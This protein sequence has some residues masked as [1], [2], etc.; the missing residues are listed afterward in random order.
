LPLRR[1]RR[2]SDRPS[3]RRLVRGTLLVGSIG[4]ALHLVFPQ[5]PGIERS[6]RLVAGTSHLL[7]GVALL[8]EVTSELSYAELLGRSVGMMSHRRPGR[9][10]MLRLT[11]T[12]YGAAHVLP[13]GGAAATAVAYG[14]LRRQGY[15]PERVGLALAAVSVLIYGA[16]GMFFS[17]S[18]LFMLLNRDLGPAD[19][20]ASIFVLGLTVSV[21]LGAYV[22]YRRPTLA[23]NVA[24]R[25]TRFAGRLLA[26]E[27]L[28][29]RAGVWSVRLVS[30]LG[31]VLQAGRQHLA[32]RSAE[33]PRLAAL[34]LGY[35]IFDALCL[36]LMF[37]ALGVAADP[38]VLLVAY[39]VAT[40]I[41]AVPLT[42]GGIGIFEVTMLATLA[43]L[44]VGSEA[45]IPI[46]G[47]RLFNFWLPIP[48]AAIFYPTLRRTG[49]HRGPGG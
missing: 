39:G 3:V 11:V 47:Y 40:A 42:P 17:G 2:I 4:L 16:L 29:Q 1:K 20:A 25:G 13:G 6:L 48:L 33:V 22:A 18:L 41:A 26:G 44:G 31:E 36:I 38:L 24:D 15:D 8:A 10:F 5:I 9:W 49:Q 34:A 7:V 21:A 43:L 14:A 28:R 45:A 27:G 46:L 23:K 32:G 19:T 37:D 35:W 12:G 30:R